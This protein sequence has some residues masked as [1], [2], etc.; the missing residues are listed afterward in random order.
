MTLLLTL[1]ALTSPPAPSVRLC[2]LEHNL[3]KAEVIVWGRIE[4]VLQPRAT[5][6]EASLARY[7]LLIE[8]VFRGDLP[9]DGRIE[10]LACH[11]W[12]CET[13]RLEYERGQQMLLFLGKSDGRYHPCYGF[14]SERVLDGDRLR[15][16]E[17]RG[18]I[19]WNA[20][21][22]LDGLPALLDFVA[23]PRRQQA[24]A[25]LGLLASH[26][27]EV[28]RFAL[29]RFHEVEFVAHDSLF[30]GEDLHVDDLGDLGDE[31]LLALW[32]Q[33][34]VLL[35]DER[36]SV[37]RAA[38]HAVVNLWRSLR[39]P[40]LASDPQVIAGRERAITQL[41]ER[42]L[43]AEG[44]EATRCL[45]LVAE[46]EGVAAFEPLLAQ[47]DNPDHHAHRE[48]WN[49][50]GELKAVAPVR[51]RRVLDR[52]AAHAAGTDCEWS[53]GQTAISILNDAGHEGTV[54]TK[55]VP[56]REWAALFRRWWADNAATIPP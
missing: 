13:R 41:L 55:D 43:H 42:S 3:R 35:G 56:M 47:L 26:D 50:M 21:E 16:T 2:T 7:T 8:R 18:D 38:I 54:P 51:S 15:R 6:S 45:L 22:F 30:G 23:V 34:I 24:A 27:P 37:N 31:S 40:G 44:D 33:V 52:L 10:V 25:W 9:A 49:A 5:A 17:V 1:I 11:D 19:A 14:Q 20:A 48:A 53:L 39:K 29:V 4:T 36:D 12:T 32:R 28:V 46:L